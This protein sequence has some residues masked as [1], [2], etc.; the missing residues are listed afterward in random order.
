[1]R[2]DPGCLRRRLADG[3]RLCLW[4]VLAFA[5]LLPLAGASQAEATRRVRL[6]T[7]ASE[8]LAPVELEVPERL[9]SRSLRTPFR[10]RDMLLHLSFFL[11]VHVDGATEAADFQVD[12][13]KGEAEQLESMGGSVSPVDW[14]D[15]A[16]TY[17]I[18]VTINLRDYDIGAAF[19]SRFKPAGLDESGRFERY[20]WTSN[21]GP[22][23]P[24]TYRPVGSPDVMVTCL[25][26]QPEM[27]CS[28]S[29]MLAK[30]TFVRVSVPRRLLP[31]WKKIKALVDGIVAVH[32]PAP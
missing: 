25:Y 17:G 28:V 31:E 6:V 27:K 3:A 30:T 14:I 26:P 13:I 22:E 4:V 29:Y 11:P 20:V 10:Y 12:R 23:S 7:E 19:D 1:M 32:S 15:T 9:I 21:D 16:R 18:T 8:H 5:V 24:K 2:V